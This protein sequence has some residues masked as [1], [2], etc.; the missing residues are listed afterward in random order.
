MSHDDEQERMILDSIDRFLE[1]D[2]APYVHELEAK[3]IWPE[4]I[5]GKMAELGLFGAMID[6]EYGGLG[7]SCSTYAKIVERIST[8]WMSLTGIFNSHLILAT[9]VQRSGT[10]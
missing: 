10:E 6:E 8:V 5:V 3:D 4:E 7:L 2:V 9:A 1:R